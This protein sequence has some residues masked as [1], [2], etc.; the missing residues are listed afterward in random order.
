MEIKNLERKRNRRKIRT[1]TNL[2][3][4]INCTNKPCKYLR[5]IFVIQQNEKKT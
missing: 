2:K 3:P 5:S 4:N 1:K